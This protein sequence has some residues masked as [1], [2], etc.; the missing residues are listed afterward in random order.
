MQAALPVGL[1]NA[2]ELIQG[3]AHSFLRKLADIRTHQAL[4]SLPPEVLEDIGVPHV[5]VSRRAGKLERYPFVI[6]PRTNS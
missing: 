5:G 3:L 6:K 4:Q 1:A 2:A